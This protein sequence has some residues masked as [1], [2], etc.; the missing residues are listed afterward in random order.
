MYGRPLST[1][2]RDQVRSII[3]DA[4]LSKQAVTDLAQDLTAVAGR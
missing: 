4:G 1:A 2:R 3:L